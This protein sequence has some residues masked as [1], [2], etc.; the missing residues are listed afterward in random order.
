M[1]I[2]VEFWE[3]DNK[4]ESDIDNQRKRDVDTLNFRLR[5]TKMKRK[6]IVTNCSP[7]EGNMINP[8]TAD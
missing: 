6:L 5:K 7:C 8:I 3:L 4:S 2:S 1:L